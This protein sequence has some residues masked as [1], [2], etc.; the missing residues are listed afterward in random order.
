MS[1]NIE[2]SNVNSFFIFLADEEEIPTN[3][4]ALSLGIRAQKKLLR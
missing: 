2:I 1:T 3:A 4:S